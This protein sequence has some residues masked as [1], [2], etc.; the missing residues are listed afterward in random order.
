MTQK[1]GTF[2][3]PNLYLTEA[4]DFG[5]LPPVIRAKA[6]YLNPLIGETYRRALRMGVKI[7][8]GTDLGVYPHGNNAKKFG[9]LAH[10]QERTFL[11][12]NRR[13]KT[14]GLGSLCIRYYG[15]GNCNR[16]GA[17][18]GVEEGLEGEARRRLRSEEA[19]RYPLYPGVPPR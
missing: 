14:S 18:N 10:D 15:E 8:F 5:Q 6:E 1:N 12:D 2:V 13:G 17:G 9:D 3:V 4:M 16:G 11:P 19:C 7:A